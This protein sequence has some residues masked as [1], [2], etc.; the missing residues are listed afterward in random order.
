LNPDIKILF[1]VRGKSVVNDS[2]AEDAYAVGIDEYAD[3]IDNGDGS[4]GTVLYRTS[5]EFKEAYRKADIVIAKGQA[6]YECLSEE[7]KTFIFC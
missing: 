6:N 5:P 1:G 2:I 4:F 7:K 3:V